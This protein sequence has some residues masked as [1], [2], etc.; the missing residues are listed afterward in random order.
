MKNESIIASNNGGLGCWAT[1]VLVHIYSNWKPHKSANLPFSQTLENL[2][3]NPILE[4]I[5]QK[6]TVDLLCLFTVK[7]FNVCVCVRACAWGQ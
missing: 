5:K 6:A 2:Q 4:Y 7:M 1:E 3:E